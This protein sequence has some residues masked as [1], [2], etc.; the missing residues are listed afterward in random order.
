MNHARPKPRTDVRRGPLRGGERPRRAKKPQN[1]P[2][3]REKSQPLASLDWERVR[4]IIETATASYT[5]HAAVLES[6][7]GAL[8]MGHMFG[9]RVLR[10]MH[11]GKTY[12]RY[13]RILGIKFNQE[14]P[15]ETPLSRR[16]TGYRLALEVG[17]YWKA[18]KETL[19]PSD[20]RP[21]LVK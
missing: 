20:S 10:I 2:M 4:N 14:C 5:G 21:E 19:I 11:D 3:S 18:I 1:K 16:S 7:I 12:H 6:A 15:A 8:I 9:W 13:E 17:N